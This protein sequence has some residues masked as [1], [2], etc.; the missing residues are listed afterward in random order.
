MR[1]CEDAVSAFSRKSLAKSFP[2]DDLFSNRF[3]IKKPSPWGEGVN[4]VDG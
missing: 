4:E 2:A 3:Y 1:G